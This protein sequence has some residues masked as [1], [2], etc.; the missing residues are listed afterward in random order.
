MSANFRVHVSARLKEERIS[1]G[2][3]QVEMA[4]EG[5]ISTRTQVAW[6]K[7]EQSPSA[8][9]LALLASKG[10]DVLYILTGRREQHLTS[11]SLAPS[12]IEE[13][14]AFEGLQ[15]ASRKAAL[16]LLQVIK[17]Q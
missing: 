2:L 9:Y 3:S 5:G 10:V 13:L 14:Q 7:G 11:E 15:E 12:Q 8:D 6:E 1:L 16:N 17:T 4:Q